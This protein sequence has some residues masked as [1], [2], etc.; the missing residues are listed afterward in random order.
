M[1]RLDVKG[2]ACIGD[3]L[4]GGFGGGDV[5]YPDVLEELLEEE[6]RKQG[7]R[8]APEVVN[9]GVNGE[10]TVTIL[11][12]AGAV[13][14][15]LT[16]DLPV[17][18]DGRAVPVRFAS[19]LSPETSLLVYGNSG[20]ERV[21]VTAEDGTELEGVLSL[22]GGWYTEEYRF[23][24]TAISGA[25]A[26]SGMSGTSAPSGVSGASAPA[27][28]RQ[29]ASAEAAQG[30]SFLV[31]RG[32]KLVTRAAKYYRDYVPI[33]LMG[34]NGFFRNT[35]ELILQHRTL[36]SFYRVPAERALILGM[37]VR[38]RREMQAMEA[39]MEAAFGSR[40]VNVR[41]YMASEGLAAAGL[42]PTAADRRAMEA[43]RVPDSL[44]SDGLHFN[45]IG[46]E[47]LGKLVYARL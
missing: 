34:A 19:P 43:G 41:E 45:S 42:T 12:R 36:L 23:R 27:G 4:T 25:S 17:P 24:L 30:K 5:S 28:D 26:P 20:A 29:P 10:D 6:A 46:Y 22:E 32:T 15:A 3:S 13:P 7:G 1:D 11:G 33:V 18:A 21:Y 38:S 35:E 14:F 37:P 8:K 39:E 31:P 47:V 40:Y 16:E 9:L 2:Y 44:L